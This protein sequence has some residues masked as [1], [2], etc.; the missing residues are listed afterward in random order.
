MI[1]EI[2]GFIAKVDKIGV[3]IILGIIFIIFAFFYNKKLLI[4]WGW[5]KQF[6][7]GSSVY[8]IISSLYFG[9][10]G[11]LFWKDDLQF[12]RFV[13]ALGAIVYIGTIIDNYKKKR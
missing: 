13:I 9:I 10:T 1:N 3:I 12:Y 8:L 2:L 11:S 6:L 7:I 4:K 5:V